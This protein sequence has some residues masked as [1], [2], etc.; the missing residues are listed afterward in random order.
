MGADAAA[1]SLLASLIPFAW[2]ISNSCSPC[3]PTLAPLLDGHA[4]ASASSSDAMQCPSH[5]VHILLLLVA[6]L[7]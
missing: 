1:A 2:V 6:R 3:C 4:H 5:A 7:A